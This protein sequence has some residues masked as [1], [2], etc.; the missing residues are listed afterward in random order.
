M[1]A[2]LAI[3]A[4]AA[5]P[6]RGQN[7]NVS[8][9]LTPYGDLQTGDTVV[10]VDKTSARA[11]PNNNGTSAAPSAVEIELS[12]DQNALTA[13]PAATLKWVVVLDNGNYLFRKPGTDDYLYN[14]TTNNGVRVSTYSDDSKFTFENGGT[15]NVPFLKNT[16]N[17]RFIGV[18]NNQ[19]W[20]SYTTINN[21]IRGCITAFYKRTVTSGGGSTPEPNQTTYNVTFGGFGNDQLNTVYEDQS[22]PLQLT[23]DDVDISDQLVGVYEAYVDDGAGMQEISVTYTSSTVTVTINSAFNGTA[24]IIVDD[25]G[26]YEASLY[27]TVVSNAPAPVPHTV[28]LAEG[29]EEAANWSLS[30]G[31]TSVPGTQVLENVMSGSQVTATYSGNRKVKSVKAVKYVTP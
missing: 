16:I 10:I 19:D 26:N 27:V 22:L 15:N 23:F 12:G 28:R 2:V 4:A 20:R 13:V 25:D 8:W 29:T 1:A 7:S 6:V 21:N 24:T 3:A 14:T 31:N 11:L 5:G 30:S 9:V 18:Y 17:S